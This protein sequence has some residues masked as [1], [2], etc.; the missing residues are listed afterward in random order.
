M[1]FIQHQEDQALSFRTCFTTLCSSSCSVQPGLLQCSLGRSS[2]SIK[3]LQ[4]FQN[5]AARFI[6]NEPKRMHVTPLFTH[7]CSHKIQGINVKVKVTY[8][9]FLEACVLQVNDTLLFI[10]KRHK[11]TFTDFYINCSLL[12]N[13][14][15]AAESLTIFK[16]Q[17]QTHLFHLYLTL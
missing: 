4:L 14:I 17:L 15:P 8:S 6:F 12:T 1:Y 3:P 9:E 16:N 10:P 5:A 13:S 11:I 7:S 2:S